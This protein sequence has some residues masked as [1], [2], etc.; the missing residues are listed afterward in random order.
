MV[1]LNGIAREDAVVCSVCERRRLIPSPPFRGCRGRWS[2]VVL[3]MSWLILVF[4][5]AAVTST[6]TEK[7]NV[8][9]GAGS[10]DLEAAAAA[11]SSSPGPRTPS[12]FGVNICFRGS[13]PQCC[14]GWTRRYG[15][16]GHCITPVCR[17]PCG[18]G[19]CVRP[20]TCRCPSGQLAPSCPISPL[21]SKPRP[22]SGPVPSLPAPVGTGAPRHITPDATLGS[23][24][25][26][27]H[28]DLV[29]RFLR[30]SF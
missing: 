19:Y 4:G 10:L 9:G 8:P 13:I 25:M 17:R 21:L 27:D 2:S 5:A 14:D 12:K 16:G 30:A 6:L 28:D 7:P 11:A 15:R 18:G 1:R 20:N 29:V 23:C 22:G 24:L 26:F 3:A